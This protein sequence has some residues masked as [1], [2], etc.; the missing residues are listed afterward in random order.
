MVDI[1]SGQ[2]PGDV[3]NATFDNGY[4]DI[5][6]AYLDVQSIDASNVQVLVDA[7]LYTKEE[8]C[9]GITADFCS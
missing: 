7:G 1:L 6:A 2:E 3:I 9:D 8:L 5:P 4:A